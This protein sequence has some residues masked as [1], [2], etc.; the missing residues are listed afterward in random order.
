MKRARSLS[1]AIAGLALAAGGACAQRPEAAALAPRETSP[2]AT[3]AAR[4]ALSEAPTVMR[5]S[6][7]EPTAQRERAAT[8]AA[9]RAG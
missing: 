9:A 1:L 5:E 2:E 3:V 4:P 6:S 7:P 8:A